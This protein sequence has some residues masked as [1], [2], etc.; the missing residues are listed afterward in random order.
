MKFTAL[1]LTL[2]CALCASS[3]SAEISPK[4]NVL[5][6][7][8]DDLK[9]L[10]GCYGDKAIKS[11]NIDRLAARGVVFE[12]AYCNQAVCAPSRNS[13]MTGVRPT[14]LGIYDLGTNFRL[15]SSNA[16]TLSQ[17][18]MRH[19]YRAE[20][21]GK[22]FHVGHGNHEDPASWS[23][24]HFQQ[25]SIAYVKPASRANQSLTREEA[26]FA[27]ETDVAKL[28]RGAAY[29]SADVADNAYPDGKIADEAVRRLR[30]AKPK[31]NEP[32]F[33]AV[34]FLKPHLPFCAPKKY[35]DLYDR[36]SFTVPAL[37]SAPEGAPRYA[38][39]GWGELRQYSDIPDS[40]S[41]TDDQARTMIHGY[42][43][44]V[45]FMDAQLGKVLDEF[46]RLGFAS[47][48]IVVLWGDHGWHL[49]DHGWWCKHDNYEQATRIPLIVAA[50]GVTTPGTRAT[51]ALVET[52]DIYPTLAELASLP[53]PQVPQGIEG[54]SFV[55]ALRDPK[56]GTKNYLYHVYPRGERIGR[57]VR[58]SR[59]RLV[60]W[61]VPGRAAESADLELY[62]YETDPLE[63][64]NLAAEQPEVVS[65]MRA[66]LVKLPEA[67][68]QIANAK[69][70]TAKQ[71]Q[72]RITLF[73]RKD[74][75]HDN[76]LTREEFLASQPDPAEAPKR[77]ERFDA[78]KDGILSRDE[79]VH[80]GA[81][82][83][84]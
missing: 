22:I 40:G 70:L 78:N 57:A 76:Q 16:I 56:L 21:L 68:P 32:F 64:K 61:K 26:L 36:A 67:K 74:K 29:E 84:K 55:A 25:K 35:W 49:G 24:P 60:E 63:T 3:P 52:V 1:G 54:K 5:L 38:P 4:P 15:A 73:E 23:V 8:V 31:P 47:N 53:A 81:E 33:L 69:P 79:F 59:Y 77:F 71:I 27:N 19:G 50:P 12:R 28:P 34:G 46:D 62:D 2:L 45:S 66:M 75:N 11:P 30:A 51:N 48:T 41:L 43:A 9:P 20:A 13:L 10:L 44:A 7:C 6:I 14:T 18:F 39:S 37:R 58:T 72:D 83:K 80:M 65:R 82:V 42:H 17:Y